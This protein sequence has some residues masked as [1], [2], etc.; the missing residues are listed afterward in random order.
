MNSPL[1]DMVSDGAAGRALAGVAHAPACLARRVAAGELGRK[2]GRGFYRWSG[3]RPEKGRGVGDAV[4][5]EAL[6]R[7]IIEPLL[8]AAA[9]CVAQGVVADADLADAGV[10]FCSGFAPWTGGP[11][12]HARLRPAPNP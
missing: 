4:Q 1:R 5:R 3:E 8:A 6:A 11:L 9:R 7:R 12:H 2:S 10:I